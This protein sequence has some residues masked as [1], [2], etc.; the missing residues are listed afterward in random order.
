MLILIVFRVLFTSYIKITAPDCRPSYWEQWSDCSVTCGKG[1]KTRTRYV[2]EDPDIY[3]QNC[4]KPTKNITL[5][6]SILCDK[7]NSGRKYSETCGG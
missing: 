5:S 7:E 1:T 3:G 6:E 4:T 2:I